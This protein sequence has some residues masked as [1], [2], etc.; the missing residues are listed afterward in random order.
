MSDVV[1][2]RREP[3]QAPVIWVDVEFR[4]EPPGDVQ[5]SER[6]LEPCMGRPRVDQVCH[7][8]LAYSP[9]AL[10]DWRIDNVALRAF[11]SNEAVNGVAN[12]SMCWHAHDDDAIV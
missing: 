11:D 2:Q 1:K 5:H 8:Q 10:E 3:N 4:A 12:I 9:K 6:V 7:R